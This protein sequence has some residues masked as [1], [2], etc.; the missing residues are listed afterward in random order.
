MIVPIIGETDDDEVFMVEFSSNIFLSVD[1]LNQCLVRPRNSPYES[2]RISSKSAPSKLTLQS[3][4]NETLT[5]S[6]G[7]FNYYP[8]IVPSSCYK[9]YSFPKIKGQA[10][11]KKMVTASM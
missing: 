11:A 6:V 1:Q 5:Y 2:C 8:E 3:D 10:T 4:S 7:S 9:E